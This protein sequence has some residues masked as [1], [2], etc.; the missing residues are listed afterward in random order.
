M[1][2]IKAIKRFRWGYL[3]ISIILCLAGASFIIF[4]N[5]SMKTG[6]YVIAGA[7][8]I[9][10]IILVVKILADRRRGF[11]FAINVFTSVLTVVCGV[12]ALIIPEEVFKLYPMFI[13]LFAVIDGTFKLQTVISAKRYKLKMW[14]FLLIFAIVTI[15][16]GFLIVRLRVGTDINNIAFSEI[17]GITLFADGLENFFSLFYFGKIVNEARKSLDAENSV[18]I[19]DD[20]VV[21]DSYRLK[22]E[23]DM[24]TIEILPSES[25]ELNASKND[26]IEGKTVDDKISDSNDDLIEELPVTNNTT[27]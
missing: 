22:D 16:G 18:N 6:S 15:V 2:L 5:H 19:Y 10:G 4:P 17:M 21:A 1:G 25:R 23:D 14:W 12:V 13:G 8:L 7:A 11:S 26:A 27:I 20:A 3:L 24:V 9:V